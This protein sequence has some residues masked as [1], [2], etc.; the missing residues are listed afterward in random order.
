MLPRAVTHTSLVTL[1]LLPS[2]RRSAPLATAPLLP[3]DQTVGSHI[4]DAI[5]VESLLHAS[6][7]ITPPGPPF[8]SAHLE[9]HVHQA[10]RQ[11]L[12]AN[13]LVGPSCPASLPTSLSMFPPTNSLV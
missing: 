7:M 12:A 5:C 8:A 10:K 3:S 9:Q 2:A 11:R 4:Q 1:L 13:A 6:A